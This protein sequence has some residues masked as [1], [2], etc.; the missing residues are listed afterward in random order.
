MTGAYLNQSG[1]WNISVYV[2]RRGLDDLLADYKVKVS[3]PTSATT[4]SPWQNPIPTLPP[5]VVLG[6]GLMALGGVPFIWR[7][8]LKKAQPRLFLTTSL[9][10]GL[11]MLV[12]LIII[13]GW[14]L[15]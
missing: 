7:R 6:G 10:G 15:A 14:L 11:L 2:R 1:W 12:G 8:P 3:P 9:L 4:T 5:A 13:A